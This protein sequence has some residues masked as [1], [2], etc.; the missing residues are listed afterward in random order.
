[1][2]HVTAGFRQFNNKMKSLYVC[3][4]PEY[5]IMY[6]CCTATAFDIENVNFLNRYIEVF[7][8]KKSD[9]QAQYG[10]GR[11]DAS[12]IASRTQKGKI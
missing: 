2:S 7:P 3:K 6:V 4:F 11:G 8:S 1:M 5:R 9:V 10:R 12:I